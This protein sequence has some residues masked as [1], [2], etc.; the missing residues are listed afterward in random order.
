MHSQYPS[1]LEDFVRDNSLSSGFRAAIIY[2]TVK[3]A[4]PN[5][6][7]AESLILL[8]NESKF[9]EA[10]ASIRRKSSY[11]DG[12]RLLVP[13]SGNLIDVTRYSRTAEMSGI[14]RVVRN[15]ATSKV[16]KGSSFAVWSNQVF[17]PVQ[18]TKDGLVLF[19]RKVWG[20]SRNAHYFYYF[21]RK[22]FFS[23]S[24]KMAKMKFL[25]LFLKSVRRVVFGRILVKMVDI[26]A[27]KA[28]YIINPRNFIIPEVPD[29][30]NSEIVRVWIENT[31]LQSARCI[32][33]DLLP[34]THPEYF[35]KHAF[36]EHVE[37]VKLL[38]VC[39]TLVVGTPVLAAEL[40]ERL[41]LPASNS[42]IKV[43]PLPVNLKSASLMSEQS[44]LPLFTFIGG[45]QARKGLMG[46]VDFLDAFDKSQIHFQIAVVG[47]PNLLSGHDEGRLYSRLLK[48]PEI[49]KAVDSLDDSAFADL[50]KSSAAVLYVSTAEGYGLPVL[51][52]LSL[53]VP[54]VASRTPVNEHFCSLYG[55]VHML[56]NPFSSEDLSD[57]NEIATR[58]PLR[59]SLVQSINVERLPLDI[60]KW[61][62]D[63]LSI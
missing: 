6:K 62:K 10:V 42:R 48:Q 8:I 45:Y 54:V 7:Q 1:G 11:W 36:G 2:M 22:L 3:G 43:L 25:S 61:A 21:I 18:V 57:L 27:P 19:N 9:E 30:I 26:Q 50:I 59:D 58:G 20:N 56:S 4:Y 63:F 46:L 5:A 34:L 53:G 51:E 15:F 13:V 28:C 29:A 41:E 49:Y 55:G 23:K 31:N 24:P 35:P 38:Q 39:N 60:E 14:P 44:N 16:G 17:G 37:Y 12:R 33:H 52:A 47:S 32:V 40:A